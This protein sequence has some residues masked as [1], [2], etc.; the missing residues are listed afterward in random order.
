MGFLFNFERTT[1]FL[2]FHS[3]P[4]KRVLVIFVRGLFGPR[5]DFCSILRGGI[6]WAQAHSIS[7]YQKHLVNSDFVLANDKKSILI[8]FLQPGGR[9]P[10]SAINSP[11]HCHYKVIAI[12]PSIENI[13]G[14][15]SSISRVLLH[16]ILPII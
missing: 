12:V 3:Y 1:H 13:I 9:A 2:E 10:S 16:N 15:L 6:Y 7:F 4:F 14:F 8:L 5:G 11:S